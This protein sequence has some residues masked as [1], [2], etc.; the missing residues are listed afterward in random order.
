MSARPSRAAL[1]ALT[2]AL[3]NACSTAHPPA[4]TLPATPEARYAAVRANEDRMRSLRARFRSQAHFPTGERASDGVL[5]VEKPD[6]FRLRLF[7]PLGITV[8]DYLSVGEQSWTSLP[9]AG[10]DER[11][12]A[13]QFAPFSRTDLGETFLRGAFA[14]P[15]QCS[16]AAADDDRVLV[17]C[18]AGSTLRRTLS[19]GAQGI[20]E[21]ISYDD[22]TPRLVI[23]YDD[24]RP[25][26]GIALPFRIALEYPQRQQRVDISIDSYEVNPQLAPALFQPPATP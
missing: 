1:G 8:F 23:R 4:P 20:A 9:L 11:E 13:A 14:F 5:L 10:T 19:I 17:S 6:R 24:Y 22:T 26:D 16:A 18:R 25:V 15:G 3:L 2:A 21:E 12:R 7:L